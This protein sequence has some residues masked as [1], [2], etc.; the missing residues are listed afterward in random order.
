MSKVAQ[1]DSVLLDNEI[2][3]LLS[4]QVTDTVGY[5]YRPFV[6]SYNH[7]IKFL[8]KS[9]LFKYTLWDN[10]NTY[11]FFLQ[12]IS[13]VGRNGR[14]LTKR[15]KL[16]YYLL[17]V[18]G[19]YGY[20]KL[21]DY[22]FSDNEGESKTSKA[23]KSALSKLIVQFSNLLSIL[24][25][26]NFVRFLAD[27]KYSSLKFQ[28]L[29]IR[30]KIRSLDFD[31]MYKGSVN[32]EFQ[33]RQV[34][35]NTLIEFVVFLLPIVVRFKRKKN[36]VH[37]TKTNDDRS[38]LKVIRNYLDGKYFSGGALEDVEKKPAEEV[39]G[40]LSWLPA[41]QCAIC[42]DPKHPE[43]SNLITSPYIT[44]C[45]HVYSY[46]CILEKL[47]RY[48]PT[49]VTLQKLQILEQKN[50]PEELA[51]FWKCLR[52]GKPVLWCEPYNDINEDAILVNE[53]ELQSED[54]NEE[55]ETQNEKN[56]EKNE[57]DRLEERNQSEND[58]GSERS[59][60]LEDVGD[61]VIQSENDSE[62]ELDSE[63]LEEE[64]EDSFEDAFEDGELF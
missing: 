16:L 3:G 45:G 62:E 64:L 28:L 2:Y 49:S 15:V 42:Y 50:D 1:L 59:E 22:V 38:K 61:D 6:T 9:L 4:K 13:L 52:C 36:H 26:A 48:S 18:V 20:E 41:S 47:E 55:N 34:L 24:K 17:F 46:S 8:L 29:N 53:D 58:S 60:D 10:S 31:K 40:E 33:S 12:N 43:K 19:E 14:K 44:N 37:L 27:G 30:T 57:V 21:S 11:G 63:E 39:E 56:A 5:F 54:E 35:W 32:Y 23:L 51:G 7:E 25:L